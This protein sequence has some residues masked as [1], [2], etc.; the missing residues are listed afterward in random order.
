MP[1][2][3][4]ALNPS[5]FQKAGL[6]GFMLP[7]R[8][9]DAKS[10]E[11][12]LRD[13]RRALYPRVRRL[14]RKFGGSDADAD[15]IV[16]ETLLAFHSHREVIDPSE[17]PMPWLYVVARN[18]TI[19]VSR[20]RNKWT[21]PTLD[22]WLASSSAEAGSAF[23]TA[24]VSSLLSCLSDRERG[25]IRQTALE[26][27]TVEETARHFGVS[28]VHARVIKHRAIRK[29][30]LMVEADVAVARRRPDS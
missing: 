11:K 18:K 3:L 10:Y 12:I 23:E 4:D 16:Q 7:P 19:D 27:R 21:Q 28:S 26:G 2:S 6:A 1:L 15:D 30:A 24:D 14:L 20:R 17:S 5:E 22:A 13:L 9:A 25:I 29:L 8:P